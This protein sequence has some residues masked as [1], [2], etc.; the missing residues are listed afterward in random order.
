MG[1]QEQHCGRSGDH[2]L[3]RLRRWYGRQ[4]RKR[5]KKAYHW[6]YSH[7]L[8]NRLWPRATAKVAFSPSEFI[9]QVSWPPWH[10]VDSFRSSNFEFNSIHR[11][12]KKKEKQRRDSRLICGPPAPCNNDDDDDDKKSIGNRDWHW[13]MSIQSQYTHVMFILKLIFVSQKLWNWYT[14]TTFIKN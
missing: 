3:I 10:D 7:S 8:R 13:G 2:R 14:C 9:S 6:I 1:E 5:S 4:S 11:E 12:R